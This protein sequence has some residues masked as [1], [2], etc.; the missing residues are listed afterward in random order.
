MK[1][2]N[3]AVNIIFNGFKTIFTILF[4]LITFPYASR[5]LGVDNIGLVQYYNSIISYFILL[6]TLGISFYAIR[7]GCKYKNDREKLSRFSSELIFI[8]VCTT[9]IS[10]LLL[11]V[12]IIFSTSTFDIKL[13]VICSFNIVF[14]AFNFDW[15]YQIKED[16]VYIS[17]R[18]F[19]FQIIS[20]IL[21]FIFVKSE[22]NYYIYAII[23]VISNGGSSILNIINSRK[24]IRLVKIKLKNLKCHIRPILIIFGS[25]VATTIYMNL[26]TV[27][28]GAINGT[29][30]VGLYTVAIKLN[31]ALKMIISSIS[32]VILARLSF[33]VAN[34]NLKEY[35]DL[36][37]KSI[38]IIFFILIPCCFGLI[39]LSSQVITIF[40][41]EQYIEANFA[42][43]V[44]SINVI[45]SVIDTILY[46]QVLLPFKREN[47]ACFATI[48][49]AIINLTLNL[50]AIK[51]FSINGAAITTL[52][53]EIGVFCIL[54]YYSNKEVKLM[55]SVK[56]ILF[57][58]VAGIPV[59]FIG[60]YVTCFINNCIFSV[61]LTIMI[62]ILVYLPI[63]IFMRINNIILMKYFL[64]NILY[65]RKNED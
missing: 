53:A 6:A 59:L 42:S 62:S 26:D 23:M 46:Y 60:K 45:F 5:V 30:D 40:S 35:E 38:N 44:L 32:T 12:L 65:R 52:T 43:K 8:L 58:L 36:L 10:Y 48:V 13:L 19:I 27:M 41:G 14:C 9:I 61:M 29:Y 2:Y 24:Y 20:L 17:I 1:K 28:I 18:S 33:Y 25:S 39:I 47:Q 21:L 49:G 7:Q 55:S 51:Y 4:P 15:L 50:F 57:Y 34:G 11:F 3:M 22:K 31:Q 63:V 37:R 64:K 16:F 54:F 56:D